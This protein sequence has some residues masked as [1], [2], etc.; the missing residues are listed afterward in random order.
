MKSTKHPKVSKTIYPKETVATP[1]HKKVGRNVPW[2]DVLPA[3]LITS[4][5]NQTSGCKYSLMHSVK[6][7]N[8]SPSIPVLVS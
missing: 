5:N 8:T 6:R 3:L 1:C 2:Q 7:D 4:G